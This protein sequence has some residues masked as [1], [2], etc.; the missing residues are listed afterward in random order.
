MAAHLHDR[1][2]T[3]DRSQAR[4]EED[5]HEADIAAAESA[6]FPSPRHATR[7]TLQAT[8]HTSYA[9]HQLTC[10]GPIL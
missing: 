2:G 1:A 6:E 10:G 5:N 3:E 7:H 8:L 4:V 9:W